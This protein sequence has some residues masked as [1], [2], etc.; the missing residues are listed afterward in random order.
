MK[1]I[2]LASLV[3]AIS[4]ACG[5]I[6]YTHSPKQNPNALVLANIEAIT[7]YELPTVTIECGAD[8]GDC[9]EI[10]SESEDCPKGSQYTMKIVC[11]YTGYQS[12][13]CEPTSC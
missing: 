10:S 7:R 13:Y 4:A 12:D 6:G 11:D 5:I 9:Y 1:K 8:S 2:M 3:V